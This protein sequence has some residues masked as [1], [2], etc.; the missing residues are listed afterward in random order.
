MT[1][2][3]NR[4]HRP[5]SAFPEKVRQTLESL[6]DDQIGVYILRDEKQQVLRIG[7]SKDLRRRIAAYFRV[8]TESWPQQIALLPRPYLKADLYFLPSEDSH[9]FLKLSMYHLFL[10][11]HH[12]RH[13]P[14]R[15]RTYL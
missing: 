1:G 7:C 8:G 5:E 9:K 14:R 11:H 2:I 3:R 12:P 10:N 4:S 6:P 15:V 13:H